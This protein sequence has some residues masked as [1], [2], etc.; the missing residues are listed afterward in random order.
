M[1]PTRSTTM[2]NKH[3]S[4]FLTSK[5]ASPNVCV[6]CGSSE[7]K[8]IIAVPKP[9]LALWS[10]HCGY[11]FKE[12]DYVCQHHFE[13]EF[14]TSYLKGVTATPT[15][16][17][18]ASRRLFS[19]VLRKPRRSARLAALNKTPSPVSS[20]KCTKAQLNSALHQAYHYITQGS[21]QHK[22]NDQQP[23]VKFAGKTLEKQCI[24][25]IFI[26]SN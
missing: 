21:K 12:G 25:Y 19:T 14:Q 13:Q 1:P 11:V 3:V 20:T 22:E 16:V 18:H 10:A 4:P 24:G 26:P 2:N 15:R 7:K 23:S 6:F 5:H 9:K 17:R 8:D